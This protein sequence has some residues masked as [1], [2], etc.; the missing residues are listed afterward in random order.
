MYGVVYCSN[1]LF[2]KFV[3]VTRIIPSLSKQTPALSG[4]FI[5]VASLQVQCAGN[6]FLLLCQKLLSRNLQAFIL[7]KAALKLIVKLTFSKL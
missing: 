1:C 7:E 5:R 6:T 2:V 3:N 4:S